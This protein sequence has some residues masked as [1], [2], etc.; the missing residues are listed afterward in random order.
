MCR[1]CCNLLRTERTNTIF[2]T[3]S[4]EH[5]LVTCILCSIR[6]EDLA[7]MLSH[8]SH[9]LVVVAPRQYQSEY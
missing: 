9:H 7:A 5:I 1:R 8:T 2:V 6:E 4:K 3:T